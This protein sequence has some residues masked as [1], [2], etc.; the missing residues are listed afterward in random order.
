[1]EASGL[2]D[3]WHVHGPLTVNDRVARGDVGAVLHRSDVPHVHAR[4]RAGADGYVQ[5]VGGV[6]SSEFTGAMYEV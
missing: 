3:N 6:F 1:M 2:F 5:E 4:P